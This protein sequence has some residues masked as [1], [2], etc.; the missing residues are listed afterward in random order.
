MELNGNREISASRSEVWS[1][2]LDPG[3]LKDC[4]PGCQE[5]TGSPE[6]GF[7]AV[8]VQKVGPVKATFRGRVTLEDMVEPES[9]TLV[10][11]GKGGP[12]GFAKGGAKVRLAETGGA[13]VL[14][15]DVEAKVGGKLA[16]LGG[17]VVDAFAKK[18]ADAFFESFERRVEG[19]GAGSGEE[20]ATP[21]AQAM[22][23]VSAT[24]PDAGHAIPDGPAQGADVAGLASTGAS[25]PPPG[26]RDPQDVEVPE[27]AGAKT[28]WLGRILGR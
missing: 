13:T 26:S 21:A 15:Y 3:V 16:Q 10:G 17:R 27:P 1:S 23:G 2:L 12:A 20:I 18:M 19:A 8:V 9:L 6:E 28:G 14:H 4:I 22:A 5:L 7:E 24:G 11:E 25:A